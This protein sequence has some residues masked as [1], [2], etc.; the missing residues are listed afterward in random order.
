MTL[1]PQR[2]ADGWLEPWAVWQNHHQCRNF[3]A[4]R[5]WTREQRPSTRG[6]VHPQLGPVISGHLNLSA[7]PIYQEEH[8]EIDSRGV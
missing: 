7:L 5:D 6:L 4:L 1:I 8:D 3:E 2:W